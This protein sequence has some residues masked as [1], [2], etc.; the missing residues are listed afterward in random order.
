ML[1]SCPRPRGHRRCRREFLRRNQRAPHRVFQKPYGPLNLN[2][3]LQASQR[4]RSQFQP[5][6]EERQTVRLSGVEHR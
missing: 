3:R 2:Q 1:S 5:G 4:A 6:S